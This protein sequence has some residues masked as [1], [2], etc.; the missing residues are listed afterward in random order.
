MSGLF[1]KIDKKKKVDYK[2]K[3]EEEVV[4]NISEIQEK[5]DKVNQ[6]LV[7][8]GESKLTF[9]LDEKMNATLKRTVLKGLKEINDL[10]DSLVTPLSESEDDK[11]NASVVSQS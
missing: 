6:V 5:L 2:L 9:D 3:V 7:N 4:K 8:N 1:T 10:H 11:P